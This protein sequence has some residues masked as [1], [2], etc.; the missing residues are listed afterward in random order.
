MADMTVNNPIFGTQDLRIDIRLSR[1]LS[2]NVTRVSI[3]G[4]TP[5]WRLLARVVDIERGIWR[6]ILRLSVPTVEIYRTWWLGR[7]SL[8][9]FVS[10]SPASEEPYDLVSLPKSDYDCGY[11]SN[12]GDSHTGNGPLRPAVVRVWGRRR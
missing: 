5:I 10:E 2:I 7:R 12:G 6:W 8:R 1:V 4:I 9:M 11:C 3:A